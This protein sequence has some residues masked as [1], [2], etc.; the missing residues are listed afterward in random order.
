MRV[1]AVANQKGG[2]GKTTTA[3]NLAA[4]LARLERR[5]LLVDNDPQGHAT[6]AFGYRERD[7][8][9]G[10]YDLY[11]T[12]D[13]LVED[14]ALAVE[15]GLHVIPAGIELSAVE[16][17]LAG[18][19]EREH[20][21]RGN[22]QRSRLPYDYV[23]IDCPPAVGLLTFNALLASGEVIVPVD[24]SGYTLQAVRKLKETL[25]ALRDKT[26]HDI[27]PRLLIANFDTRPRY[28]QVLIEELQT[29]YGE[30]LF[31]TIVHHTVRCKEA[32]GRGQPVVDY[33]PASRGA[34]DFRNL[35]AEVVAQETDLSVTDL[36]HW[37]ALLQGPRVSA[38]GVRFLADFPR[39]Q[40]V[41][42]TG[43]F[44]AWS[45]QGVALER[46]ADGL[47]ECELELGVGDHEYRYI[48]DGAWLPDPHNAA[49]VTN[50]FGGA[51]SLVTVP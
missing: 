7:F 27:L 46:R 26:G 30:Q 39:A 40:S 50:E 36:D 9:L 19:E 47:W 35:A 45:A 10:T 17:M 41:R 34:L 24:P 1:I 22:L 23:L 33:D 43:E 49:A 51:N 32:A 14:A 8:T 44:C 21:L 15:S 6:L 16:Q 38:A 18:E 11:L 31:D 42:L 5:V 20:R 37:V 2:C 3:T 12:S 28:A 29:L 4:T 48:V 13:I 25:S